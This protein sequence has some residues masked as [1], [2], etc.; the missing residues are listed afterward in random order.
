MDLQMKWWILFGTFKDQMSNKNF[1][2]AL[3]LEGPGTKPA[4]L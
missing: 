1:L 4:A 3:G 2:C